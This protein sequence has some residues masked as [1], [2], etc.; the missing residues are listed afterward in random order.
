MKWSTEKN[1]QGT[2]QRPEFSQN[3]PSILMSNVGPL[4]VKSQRSDYSTVYVYHIFIIIHNLIFWDRAYSCDL[5]LS[6]LCRQAEQW[7]LGIYQSLPPQCRN[8]KIYHHSQIFTY[9]LD[10]VHWLNYLPSHQTALFFFK[11]TPNFKYPVG[12]YISIH[13]CVLTSGLSLVVSWKKTG[14]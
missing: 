5:G 9:M 14:L 1:T 11:L 13:S 2:K 6:N 12:H 8:Y 3:G 10:D 7:A 4:K